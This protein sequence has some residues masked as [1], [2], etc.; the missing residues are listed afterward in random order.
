MQ[1]DAEIERI[2]QRII[3]R[4][5]SGQSA[6]TPEYVE[7]IRAKQTGTGSFIDRFMVAAGCW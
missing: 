7:R 1:I 6:L 4:V 3:E 5:R 2:E